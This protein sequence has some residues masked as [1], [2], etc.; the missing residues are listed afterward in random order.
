M[1]SVLREVVT[2]IEM[3]EVR[4]LRNDRGATMRSPTCSSAKP[5]TLAAT[6]W[7][8]LVFCVKLVH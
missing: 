4:Q 1:K 5:L 7:D 2:G 8:H 3:I 6:F